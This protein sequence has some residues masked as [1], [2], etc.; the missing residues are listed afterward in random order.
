MCPNKK[1]FAQSVLPLPHLFD[2][3]ASELIESYSSARCGRGWSC[4]REGRLKDAVT[5][6]LSG[7]YDA[8]YQGV[9]GV[10]LPLGK[11]NFDGFRHG[12]RMT[13]NAL[14]I[15]VRYDLA[16]LDLAPP[17][18]ATY[19]AS[20]LKST[21]RLRR[22]F[23]RIGWVWSP[24]SYDESREVIILRE[25]DDFLNEKQTLPTPET[26]VVQKMRTIVHAINREV[27]KHAVLP[28]LPDHF[29]QA[30]LTGQ[31]PIQVNLS[32]TDYRRIFAN[33]RLDEGGRF[34]GPWWQQLPKDLRP[35]IQIDGKPTVELD[36]S[37]M[38]I[39]L[40]YATRGYAPPKD[41]YDLSP[42][43]DYTESNRSIVKRFIN[44]QLNTAVP[45]QLRKNEYAQLG[46]SKDK[47][48][49]LVALK[50]PLVQDAFESTVGL[51]LQYLDSEIA[52]LVMQRLFAQKIP[53]LC[54]H[55][56]FIVPQ[57]SADRLREAMVSVFKLRTG[58]V[59]GVRQVAGCARRIPGAYRIYD[60]FISPVARE[61]ATGRPGSSSL[62][63]SRKTEFCEVFSERESS[64]Q[65]AIIV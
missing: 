6:L 31:S 10:I 27:S 25:K 42:E 59:P 35:Y 48:T 37:G 14:E 33:G 5:W 22:Q 63:G 49:Q 16:R 24:R 15:L 47:L 51:H 41:P 56:S 7:L 12:Y 11:A 23:K 1:V 61:T 64:A 26:L 18:L 52:S 20:E 4:A 34:Y 36:Y 53:V 17:G 2:G 65:G 3:L 44:A 32:A 50:H 40:L 62:V 60:R 30:M 57:D 8:H 43:I 28:Y 38:A 58:V 13:Q 39:T 54:I 45:Y 29:L 21:D 19:R 46:V 9:S 55:D